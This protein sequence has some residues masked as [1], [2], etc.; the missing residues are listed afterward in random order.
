MKQW[1]S[2][3]ITLHIQWFLM[4]STVRPKLYTIACRVD[5]GFTSK[6]VTYIAS[7]MAHIEN[8]KPKI[9]NMVEFGLIDAYFEPILC[10]PS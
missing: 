1:K 9:W 8:I 2:V 10:L 5:K 6:L 3:K 7:K 4:K